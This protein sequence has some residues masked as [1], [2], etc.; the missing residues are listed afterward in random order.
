MECKKVKYNSKK[1]A[2]I[3]IEDIKNSKNFKSNKSPIR[4]YYCPNCKKYHLTS[5]TKQAQ[6]TIA[7][8]NSVER[9]IE[10]IANEFI[11]KNKWYD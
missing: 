6:K 4:S 7:Q 11:I 9:R 10:K 8:K 3:K 2:I 5:I 1:E